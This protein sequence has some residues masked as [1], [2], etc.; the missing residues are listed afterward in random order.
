V[1]L[2]Q[3]SEYGRPGWNLECTEVIKQAKRADREFRKKLAHDMDWPPIGKKL[4]SENGGE[5]TTGKE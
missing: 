5:P 3:P 1:K 2:S 4:S